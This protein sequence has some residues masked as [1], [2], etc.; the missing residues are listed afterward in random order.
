MYVCIYVC[1]SV[2]VYVLIHAFKKSLGLNVQDTDM[3][4]RLNGFPC[5]VDTQGAEEVSDMN[6]LE[7]HT[8]SHTHILPCDVDTQR[9]EEVSDGELL[10]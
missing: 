7:L 10:A 4:K 9:A 2:C 8:L 6:S 3:Q 1:M 5:Y